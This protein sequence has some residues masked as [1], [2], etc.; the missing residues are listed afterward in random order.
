MFWNRT[1]EKSYKVAQKVE[2]CNDLRVC[3]IALYHVAPN[4]WVV[5]EAEPMGPRHCLREEK[6]LKM[7]VFKG[8][9]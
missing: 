1:Q 2:K 6:W 8:G 9:Q 7:S 4:V 5:G 3:Y